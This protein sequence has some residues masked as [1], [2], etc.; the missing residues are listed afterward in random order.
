MQAIVYTQYGPPE[1]LQLKEVPKPTPKDNQVLIKVHASSINAAEIHIVKG[2]PFIVRL[3]AGGIFKPSKTI[4]GADV[5]GRVEAVGRDVKRFKPGDEVFGDLSEDG[6]GAFAEYA[7][8]R[9]DAL[10]LKP[11]N[12]S[13]ESAAAVP[14]AGVTALQALRDTGKIQ[15][16]QKVLINGASGGVG[17]FA[18]QIAKGFGA[19]VTGVCSTPKVELV[20]SIGADHVIDYKQTDITQQAQRYDLILDN[21]AYHAFHDYRR[22]LTPTG[23]YMVVGGS[24]TRLFQTMLQGPLASKRDGQRFTTVMAKPGSADLAI[25]KDLI[26]AGTVTPVVDRCFPLRETAEAFR[27]FQDGNTK[28]KVVISIAS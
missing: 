13:F 8:A 4:P 19:E 7:C 6:W 24:T 20:R 25:L 22:L 1:V 2:T 5:A 16:G 18:V 11:K 12:V 26:E 17:T 23:I 14:L 10:V 9:E 28:G 15:A 3:M 21:A 27:Y